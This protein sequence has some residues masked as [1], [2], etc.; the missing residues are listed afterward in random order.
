[1]RW[2]WKV[3]NAA[4]SALA[5]ALAAARRILGSRGAARVDGARRVLA[6]ERV[7]AHQ[8]GLAR[9]AVVNAQPCPGSSPLPLRLLRQG[10]CSYLDTNLRP[11]PCERARSSWKLP[12]GPIVLSTRAS[13]RA[14][15]AVLR[16]LSHAQAAARRQLLKETFIKH[17]DYR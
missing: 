3:S 2:S 5:F 8:L 15:A 11:V 9:D 7:P 4:C 16:L 13:Y 12:R 17:H 10:V 14:P 6:A 1:M